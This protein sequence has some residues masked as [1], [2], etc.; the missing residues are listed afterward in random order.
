MIEL[1]ATNYRNKGIDIIRGLCILAVVLLHLNIHFGFSQSFLKELVPGK[2]FALFFWSGYYGVIVFFTLSG[3]LI[4][5]SI[6]RKW[7]KLSSIDVKTFYWFR[8][9]RIVPLLT[10]LLFVLSILHITKTEGFVIN[11][12]KTTL[13][14]A[15]VS[16]LCF[17][18][19]W[20]QIKVGYL[21]ANWD[22]LWSISIEEGFYILFPILCLVLRKHKY[23][24]LV[25][26]VSM[27]ISPWA[28]NYLFPENDLGDRNHLAYLDSIALGC[29]SAILIAKFELRRITRGLFAMTGV[30][31]VV[32]ILYFRS[33]V[34]QIGLTKL[35]LNITIL[36]L[37][38]SFILLWIHQSNFFTKTRFFNWLASFGK[39]SYE[40]YLTHMFVILLAA[41]Y[42]RKYGFTKEWLFPF[43][44]TSILLTYVLGKFI[45]HYFSDPLN[46][47][48]RNKWL[49]KN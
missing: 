16:A 31:F 41:Q 32:F 18:I 24:I 25:V 22:V 12:E 26:L 9:A 37:G 10:L 42:F 33:F 43:A 21:P 17:H 49:S 34:Y 36:S 27:L 29:V 7:G 3:F 20:L 14:R 28:R 23:F 1:E 38:V 8:F 11:E 2:P 46:Q 19:N 40:I 15:V 48:L 47:W 39:Y 30:L 4:T 5:N 35:G 44:L 6:L 45:F 13:A